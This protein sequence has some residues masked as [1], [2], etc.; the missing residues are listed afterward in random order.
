M[1]FTRLYIHISMY[2]KVYKLIKYKNIYIYTI[3]CYAIIKNI[4]SIYK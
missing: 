4:H 1:A 3:T 2:I